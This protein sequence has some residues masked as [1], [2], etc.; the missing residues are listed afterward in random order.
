M[1]RRRVSCGSACLAALR[2]WR[3]RDRRVGETS[4]PAPNDRPNS[5]PGVNVSGLRSEPSGATVSAAI[6]QRYSAFSGSI[7]AR[8]GTFARRT[9]GEMS[10]QS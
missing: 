3:R 9:A 7:G 6:G 1:L 5:S 8:A 2:V 4:A 10:A